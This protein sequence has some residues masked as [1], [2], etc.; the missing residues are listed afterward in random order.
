LPPAAQI[1]QIERE[2]GRDAI[3]AVLNAGAEREAVWI[4]WHRVPNFLAS[5]PRDY[6]YVLD[7]LSGQI[8]FGDGQRGMIP[9]QGSN[10]V[11][12]ASYRTGGGKNGNR[13]AGA[14][15]QLASA[16]PFVTAVTNYSPSAGG[17]DQEDMQRV[18][19]RGPTKLRNRG[20]AVAAQDFEDLAVEAS[21]EVARAHAITPVYYEGNPPP[22]DA[23]PYGTVRLLIVPQSTA[24][25][26]SPSMPLI[27]RVSRYILDRSPSTLVNLT[28]ERPLWAIVSVTV[29]VVPKSIDSAE[30]L[31][32]TVAEKLTAALQ[33]LT[34]GL[35]GEGWTFG[36]IPQKSE[37]Y[38]I[39]QAVPG[40][41][42]VKEPEIT[43]EYENVPGGVPKDLGRYLTVSGDH[44]VTVANS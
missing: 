20:L 8:R 21:S 23:Q 9:P 18:K 7:Y 44:K 13:P 2:E 38:A 25:R 12:A 37:I 34:G 10:N 41:E 5:G 31:A 6:H 19:Q 42:F 29:T 33:P 26:P 32:T 15:N 35:R 43:I 39:I 24:P 11:R 14:I 22:P 4:R 16:F 17:T 40:V 36:T 30:T 3:T 27:E 1:A 28:V